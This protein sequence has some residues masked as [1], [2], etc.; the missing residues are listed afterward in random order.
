MDVELEIRNQKFE[1]GRLAVLIIL[2]GFISIV[3]AAPVGPDSLNVTLNETW[4]GPNT[5]SNVNV[6][7][8]LISKLNVSTIVQNPHWK[9]F[10]GWVDGRFTLDDSS[11]SS[12]YDWSI[13]SI[14]GQVY[15]TRVSGAVDWGNIECASDAEIIAEDVAMDHV[16]E[17]NISSTFNGT[18]AGTYV[19]SGVPIGA[20]DCFAVNSYVNNASQSSSF[21]EIILYDSANIVFAAKIEDGIAGYDGAD[22]DF[23]MIVP[24]NGD[25]GFAG[26]TAY[27]LYVELN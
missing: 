10:V 7:G 26:S 21:E 17:D 13:S 16:G 8:G 19:V 15:A 6:S 23:Q 4:G 20:T 24:E 9:A 25:S 14:G 22:Y 12:I 11:D 1:V 27:Y 5:G 2:F 3:S 18:N